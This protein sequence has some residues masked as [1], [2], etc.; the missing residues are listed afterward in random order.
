MSKPYIWAHRG[1]AGYA[2]E[3]TL[4]A[5]SLAAQMG[6][7]G[8]ELDVQLSKDG[9][10]VVC[11]DEKLNRTSNGKGWL[12][13]FTLEELK[14][15]DFSGGDVKY[16]GVQI[17]TLE[18][19]LD[20]LRDTG[21]Y[22]DIELKTSV[23]PYLGIEKKCV[24]LIREMG[25]EERVHFSSFNHLSLQKIRLYARNIPTGYLYLHASPSIISH[26]KKFGATAMN[27]SCRNLKTEDFV[28][29]CRENDMQ[30]NVWTVNDEEEMHLSMEYD[31]HAVITDYPDKIRQIRDQIDT[32]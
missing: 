26:A 27:I 19:V 12:R 2:P 32:F 8:V 3:N 1:A 30:I 6:A 16:A 5:F 24:R 29:K 7:D 25:Y 11:H 22:V 15:L 13:D 9:Q 20:L 4:E 23:Y 21:M 14:Q 17:P 28:E 10:I 18:E 31:V